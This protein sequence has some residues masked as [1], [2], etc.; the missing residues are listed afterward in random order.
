MSRKP[1][2]SLPSE[3][4]HVTIRGLGR[5]VIFEDEQDKQKLLRLLLNKLS[6]TDVSVY[7]WCLMDNHAHFLFHASSENLSKLMHRLGTSYAQYYNGRHGHVGKVFQNRFNAQPIESESHLFAAIRY[8]HRNALDT[9]SKLEQYAWSSYREIICRDSDTQKVVDANAVLELF[10]GLDHFLTFHNN[11]N[12][13]DSIV[14][15][16]NYRRKIDDAEARDIASKM[17][18][19][20]FSDR[21]C[22]MKKSD[23]NDALAKLRYAGL[24]IR[25]IERLIGVGRGVIGRISP[26]F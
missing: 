5:R 18:G 4:S 11:E 19:E 9:G 12:E 15:I 24:S 21:I 13:T 23:R 2:Y 6:N 14:R 3:F 26:H 25:Q 16:D 8:I 10:E 7:A 17:F 1:R 20:S 22:S